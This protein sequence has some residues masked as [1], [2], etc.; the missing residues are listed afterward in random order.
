MIRFNFGIVSQIGL[1]KKFLLRPDVSYSQ[2]GWRYIETQGW[3]S[4]SVIL[5]YINIP[6][7]TGYKLTPKLSFLLGPELGFPLKTTGNMFNEKF[8]KRIDYGICV[9]SAYSLTKKLGVEIRYAYGLS[10]LHIVYGRDSNNINAGEIYRD[11][12]NRVFQ[13]NVFYFLRK[14]CLE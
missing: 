7:L 5:H 4:S 12:F 13:V 9:A 1:S 3:T 10:P 2:K 8:G 11:G 14:Q 6:I